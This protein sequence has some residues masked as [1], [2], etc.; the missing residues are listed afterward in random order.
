MASSRM[1]DQNSI[2]NNAP[3]GSGSRNRRNRKVRASPG[4]TE[5]LDALVFF[6]DMLTALQ[7]RAEDG[8]RLAAEK[9]SIAEAAVDRLKGIRDAIAND[10]N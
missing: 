2:L 1:A 8:D 7:D 3:M 10:D 4:G 6:V 5:T 9:V